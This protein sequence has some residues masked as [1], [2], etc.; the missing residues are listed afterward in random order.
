MISTQKKSLSFNQ[1]Q[2]IASTSILLYQILG[3]RLIFNQNYYNLMVLIIWLVSAMML[4]N[5]TLIKTISTKKFLWMFSLIIYILL[6]GFFSYDLISTIKYSYGFLVVISPIFIS[7]YI[8][9]YNNKFM[10]KLIIYI[11][12]LIITYYAIMNNSMISKYPTI[13]RQLASGS[14]YI[15]NFY[16]GINIGGGYSLIYGL[17]FISILL[18]SK[19]YKNEIKNKYVLVLLCL[20]IYTI[21]NSGYLIAVLMTFAGILLSMN[22][23]SRSKSIILVLTILIILTVAVFFN[24]NEIVGNFFIKIG[25]QNDFLLREKVVEIGNILSR[26]QNYD[27]ENIEGRSSRIL[28]SI[29]SFLSS[30][31]IG[32]GIRT[33][34]NSIVEQGIIGQHSEWFDS[35]ARYGILGTILLVGYFAN[36]M[37]VFFS[38]ETNSK[39]SLLIFALLGVLNPVFNFTIIFSVFFLNR[40]INEYTRSLK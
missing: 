40:L 5:K 21:I 28:I 25:E 6:T 7:D 3:R 36:A 31:I 39:V 16:Y 24:V 1:I 29:K 34:Y 13:A 4:S 23:R 38:N 26:N 33:G 15:F 10:V 19:Y 17:V 32:N 11:S 22:D 37:K 8:I 27:Y 14:D 20:F 35:L 30:P 12:L 18:F 9:A 2:F